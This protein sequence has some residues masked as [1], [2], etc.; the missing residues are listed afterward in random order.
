MIISVAEIGGTGIRHVARGI[1][2]GLAPDL[3]DR[4]V[5]GLRTLTPPTGVRIP[6]PQPNLRV[7][8]NA[9]FILAKRG[10]ISNPER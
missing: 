2:R 4:P 1:E 7:F 10:Y 8:L 9:I 6:L 3:G 5:V